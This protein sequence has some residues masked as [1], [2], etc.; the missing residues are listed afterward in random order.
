[1]NKKNLPSA[2]QESQAAF[3]GPVRVSPHLDIEEAGFLADSILLAE[4]TGGPRDFLL[5]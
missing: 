4:L 3:P 2:C 1:V 5:A